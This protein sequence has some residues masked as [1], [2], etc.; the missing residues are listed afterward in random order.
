MD[1]QLLERYK[2][3]LRWLRSR[4]A[5]FAAEHPAAAAR[6][7]I[8][9]DGCSDPHTERLLESVALLA[10]GVQRNI[11]AAFPSV[12]AQIRS[13]FDQ[14]ASAM[15]P[16]MVMCR[17]TPTSETPVEGVSI[18][19]GTAFQAISRKVQDRCTLTTCEAVDL[20]LLVIV[21]TTEH[22]QDVSR[23]R[24]P[25][26][27]QHAIRLAIDT[28]GAC[29]LRECVPDSLTIHC[30]GDHGGAV[31]AALLA[32]STRVF[33]RGGPSQ[34]WHA[35]SIGLPRLSPALS[36]RSD[37]PV[38]RECIAL[39]ERF[40]AVRV[41][42]LSDVCCESPEK[43]LEIVAI[44]EQP[45]GSATSSSSIECALHCVPLANVYPKQFEIR[46]DADV[47]SL[48]VDPSRPGR[49]DLVSVNE[50]RVLDGDR[51][52]VEPYGMTD[53]GSGP[54]RFHTETEASW[55]G[56]GSRG[57]LTALL[58]FVEEDGSHTTLGNQ[59][60]TVSALVTDGETM[61]AMAAVGTPAIEVPGSISTARAEPLGRVLPAHS[62]AI[63]G[64]EAWSHVARTH[65][66]PLA[67]GVPGL[68]QWFAGR[69]SA[70]RTTARELARGI[71]AV[72][73]R[74]VR[75]VSP[76]GV[77]HGLEILLRLGPAA[78]QTDGSC[79]LLGWLAH[80]ALVTRLAS[81]AFIRTGVW[82]REDE[83]VRFQ[84]E[85]GLNSAI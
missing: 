32:P 77:S 78:A 71:E 12:I 84:D 1:R 19:R 11:D 69:V 7:G 83:I 62:R 39:P 49:F 85:A 57:A 13:G 52:R 81:H 42:G 50:V 35:I 10:A 24:L 31:H 79:V 58:R 30:L 74:P 2:Q 29:E 46:S 17:L 4:T 53:P 37:D 33:A 27:A 82:I 43:S 9:A 41:S 64:I 67:D 65:A 22:E 55:D 16:A 75:S 59:K 51:T 80:R 3:E 23:F 45:L 47:A 36:S 28:L 60:L 66:Q 56:S 26:R 73:S 61:S 8:S 76:T 70:E 5:L 68:L 25:I 48:V 15:T 38:A 20:R 14:G 6:L 21:E 44:I 63:D 34:P 72:E 18:S 40:R 54:L